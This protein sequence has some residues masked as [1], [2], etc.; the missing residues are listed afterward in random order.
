MTR[1]AYERI[2]AIMEENEEL[3]RKIA[4]ARK[5]LERLREAKRS[6]GAM[7]G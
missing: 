5:G 6:D 1:K 4:L 3:R 2:K 7:V